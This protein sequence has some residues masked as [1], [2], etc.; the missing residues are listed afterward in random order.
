MS[1][2]NNSSAQAVVALAALTLIWGY[3]W[4]VINVALTYIMVKRMGE[5]GDLGRRC[6]VRS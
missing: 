6:L 2:H 5:N 1:V 4:V 3:N